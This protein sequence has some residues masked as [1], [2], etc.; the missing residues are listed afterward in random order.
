MQQLRFGLLHFSDRR[1]VH[2][3]A[4]EAA[5]DDEMTYTMRMLGGEA[6]CSHRRNRER[7]TGD[8]I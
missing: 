2:A 4:S 8:G 7:Y 6:D 5:N 3:E 1:I